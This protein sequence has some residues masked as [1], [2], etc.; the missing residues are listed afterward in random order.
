M[1]MAYKL[2]KYSLINIEFFFNKI[3]S[4]TKNDS[5]STVRYCLVYI[6]QFKIK[7]DYL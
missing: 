3:K 2:I 6:I 7:I 1:N 4:N 5:Y